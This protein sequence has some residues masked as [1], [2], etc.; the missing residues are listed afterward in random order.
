MGLL[1]GARNY[2]RQRTW[3][4]SRVIAREERPKQSRKNK[5]AKCRG[6]MHRAST[7]K[8]QFFRQIRKEN[9][10]NTQGIKNI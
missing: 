5:T 3:L 6:A 10:Q 1:V 4:V 2:E 7:K 9:T 8:N